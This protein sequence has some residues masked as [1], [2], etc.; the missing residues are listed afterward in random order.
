MNM[1]NKEKAFAIGIKKGLTYAQAAI[2]AGYAP[3]CASQ[4]ATKLMKKRDVKEYL[5]IINERIEDKAVASIQERQ[6]LLTQILREEA[7]GDKLKAVDLLNK[8]TNV[9]VT[10]IEGEV[11]TTIR[12]ELDD[13]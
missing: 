7:V 10:R 13:E 3:A 5:D 4:T 9:Y 11:E 1:T 8:M 12:V 2:E 6:E